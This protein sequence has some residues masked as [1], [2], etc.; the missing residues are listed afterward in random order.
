MNEQQTERETRVAAALTELAASLTAMW[1]GSE[2]AQELCPKPGLSCQERE[3]HFLA[4][5]EAEGIPGILAYYM[6]KNEVQP[7]APAEQCAWRAAPVGSVG[8]CNCELCVNFRLRKAG[9]N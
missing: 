2:A 7:E 3:R 9:V 1:A 4:A 6:A 8:G 5:L